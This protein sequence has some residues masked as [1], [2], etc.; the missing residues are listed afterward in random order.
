MAE[1]DAEKV[2]F[3]SDPAE[4]PIL[5]PEVL[6]GQV[7]GVPAV[8]RRTSWQTAVAVLRPRNW[9]LVRQMVNEEAKVAGEKYFYAIPF[10]QKDG[11]VKVVSDG[12]IGLA[13]AFLRAMGNCGVETIIDRSGGDEVDFISHMVDLERGSNI[14]RSVTRN[15]REARNKM[16]TLYKKD[17]QRFIDINYGQAQSISQRNAIRAMIPDPYWDE[18]LETAKMAAEMRAKQDAD[19]A[20]KAV[21]FAFKS[22]GL[23]PDR[24][25]RALGKPKARWSAEDIT[26]LRG[27]FTAL[28][29]ER[30]TLES[31]F[32]EVPPEPA[33]APPPPPPPEKKKA[34]PKKEPPPPAAPP[35]E[36]Q[37]EPPGE[38]PPVEA[39]P[40]TEQPPKKAKGESKK[41]ATKQEMG[42]EEAVKIYTDKGYTVADA[43]LYF[44]IQESFDELPQDKIK[45]FI[46]FAREVPAKPF[47]PA[48]A[49]GD[50][51]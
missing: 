39:P 19:A 8:Q 26:T 31:V 36:T 23:T 6:P 24:L 25:E 21:A 20:E 22:Y 4:S 1:F 48:P 28:K 27:I 33:P 7:G 49:E 29:E 47:S 11:Q 14:S 18:A 34:E 50:E 40:E 41:K 9:K 16:P 13:Y 35:A 2:S 43:G 42:L 51:W 3:A 46:Q 12:S 5:E 15:I 17:F 30:V 45:D 38:A 44:P 10:T 32:P 37:E